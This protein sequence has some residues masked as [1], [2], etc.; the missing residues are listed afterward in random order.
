[1]LKV[2]LAD[3]V[4][5]GPLLAAEP[6]TTTPSIELK[7]EFGGGVVI[8]GCRTLHLVDGKSDWGV[9]KIDDG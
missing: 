7:K 2:A 6:T 3:G 4:G 1:M 9:G 8:T 5:P